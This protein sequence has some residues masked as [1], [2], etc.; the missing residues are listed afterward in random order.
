MR[1]HEFLE[2]L[3]YLFQSSQ[4]SMPQRGQNEKLHKL[5]TGR[6]KTTKHNNK[7]PVE[8]SVTLKVK[9]M[10]FFMFDL[11]VRENLNISNL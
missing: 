2:M 11:Q 5:R 6:S 4:Q 9:R 8:W 1:Q 10:L 3:K 7:I